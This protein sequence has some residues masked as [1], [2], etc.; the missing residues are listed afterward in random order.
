MGQG[1]LGSRKF[2]A[3]HHRNTKIKMLSDERERKNPFFCQ[4]HAYTFCQNIPI[5]AGVS[6]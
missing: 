6:E 5:L 2:V 1:K 4:K 3:L